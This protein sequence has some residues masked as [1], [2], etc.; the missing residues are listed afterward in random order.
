RHVNAA[1][2][3]AA[4]H[5]PGV[6][7]DLPFAGEQV[8]RVL[9]IDRQPGAA[10]VLVDEQDLFPA[11]AAVGRFEYA[12]LVLRARRPAERADI[13]DVRVGRVNDDS[14]N[15]PGFGETHVRPGRS[16]VGRLVDAVA[17]QVGVADRPRLA[18]ARPDRRRPRFGHGE[19][20]DRLHL[21]R[22]E[23]RPEGRA[24]V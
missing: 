23:N 13:Y 10:G 21:H 22:V 24:A 17:D 7:H 6:H 19:R 18:G 14:L 15:A 1:P 20:A 4:E 16:R 8:V 2:R 9:R 5:R 11:L 12:T 3:A